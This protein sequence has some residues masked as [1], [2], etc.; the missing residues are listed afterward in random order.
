MRPTARSGDEVRKLLSASTARALGHSL[1][2][3]DPVFRCIPAQARCTLVDAALADGRMRA[4]SVSYHWGT[5]PWTIAPQLGAA[6]VESD[7]DAGFGSVVVFA[8]YTRQPPTIKL[9]R[10]AI[11]Q[12]R[13]RLAVSRPHPMFA[14]LDCKS[15]FLAHELYH[16]LVHIGLAAQ[17]SR[18]HRVTLLRLGRWRWTSGIASLEEIAAGAF[19]Q[20]LLSLAY[21]PR[22]LDLLWAQDLV[23]A[24][25]AGLEPNG[26]ERTSAAQTA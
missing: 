1:L 5:N 15:I 11:A 2:A 8:E 24:R 21:H 23:H 10:T 14:D 6:V 20:S 17:L 4:E 26:A 25:P 12:M 3:E 7:A 18:K 9:Y 19:A 16:H 22:L 13:H